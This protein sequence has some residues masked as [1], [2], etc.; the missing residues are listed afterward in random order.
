MHEYLRAFQDINKSV[1]QLLIDEHNSL[2]IRQSAISLS[3]SV[4]LCLGELKQSATRIE[5]LVQVACDDIQYAADVWKSKPRI[6]KA[7]KDQI[8]EQL[9]ELSECDVRIRRLGERCKAQAVEK[10]KQSWETRVDRLINKYFGDAKSGKQKD[11]I[12]WYAGDLTQDLRI[13]VDL[14]AKDIDSIIKENMILISQEIEAIKLEDTQLFIALLDRRNKASLSKDINLIISQNKVSSLEDNINENIKEFSESVV[15]AVNALDTPFNISRNQVSKLKDDV[16]AKLEKIIISVL[17]ER[18]E[19]ANKAIAQASAFYNYFLE[20][21]E[22]YQQETPEQREA[23]KA[24]INQQRQQL[25][26]VQNGI[27]AI[28]NAI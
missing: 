3:E 25:E 17:D 19:L 28:L 12:F 6:A 4:Q 16:I 23:E 7:S 21:Q 10:V 2:E 11:K 22:R 14:Q 20:R 13:E 18:L 9:G 5:E 8:W 24:W 15:N 1:E 27:E 26:Q